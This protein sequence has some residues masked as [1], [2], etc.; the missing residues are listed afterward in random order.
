[1]APEILNAGNGY[2]L[3]VDVWALGIILFIMLVGSG[4]CCINKYLGYHPFPD[5]GAEE[6]EKET[7]NGKIEMNAQDQYLRI[8]RLRN[9][10]LSA[11]Q[12]G[13]EFDHIHWSRISHSAK[14]L[15]SS[16]LTMDPN[17]RITVEGAL[18][19]E[20]IKSSRKDLN[21]LYHKHVTL[22]EGVNGGITKLMIKS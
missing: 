16:L 14:S 19:S 21:I 22:S 13:L 18:R 5:N 12:K 3:S 1:M 15:V 6:E 8:H 9:E 2:T 11:I 20:W 4:F 17:K 10:S 7:E